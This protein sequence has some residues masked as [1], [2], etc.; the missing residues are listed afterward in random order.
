MVVLFPL[1]KTY[2]KMEFFFFSI[3][4]KEPHGCP[5]YKIIKVIKL[6]PKYFFEE[7]NDLL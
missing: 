5:I 1:Y 2:S 6:F 3:L 4:F 7:M